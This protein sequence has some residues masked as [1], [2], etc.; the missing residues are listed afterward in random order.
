MK[1]TSVRAA[2]TLLAWIAAPSAAAQGGR[3]PTRVLVLF[4]QQAETQPMVEFTDW[5]RR[6]IRDEL[7]SPV[8][9]Y[10]EA[11][12]LDR[13]RGAGRVSPLAGYF[14]DKYRGF[15]I[16]VVVPVGGRALRF[17]L[18]HLTDILPNA[19]IVFA[20]NAA[21]QLEAVALP[22]NVTGRFAASSRFAP[23]LAMARR[24]QPGAEQVVVIAGDGTAD[25]NALSAAIGA[26]ETL[27]DTLPVT[28][29][30]G[31]TLQSLLGTLRQLSPR[32]IVL[33]A[34]FRQD[35][36]GQVFE[37]L[38]IIGSLARASA[39][40]MY[41][42]LRS[43]VGEGVVGGSVTSFADEGMRTAR[44]IV[45]VLRRRPG[46][47]MPR[48]EVIDN[49]FAVDWRQLRRWGLSEQLLPPAT[50]VLFREPTPWE[51]YRA[52]VLLALGLISAESFL[53]GRLL[54]ERRRRQ[55]AQSAVEEQ[56]EYERTMAHLTADTVRHA[57]D[58][59]PRGLE[60]ALARVAT[61]AGA[62]AAT[63]VQFAEQPLEPPTRLRW[64][65]AAGD[66]NGGRAVATAALLRTSRD[67]RIEIPL[68]ADGAV[69]GSLELYREKDGAG[70]PSFVVRRLDAAAEIIA[71]G[72][73]RARALQG[74]RRGEELNRAV[75]ASVST[76]I[77]LL[78]Q[79]GTIIRA[80]R[81][82]RDLTRGADVDRACNAFV[83]WNYLEEC[84]RAQRRGCDDAGVVCRGIE[85]VL[86]Q[87][88][89]PFRYEYHWSVPDERWYELFVDRLQLSEGGAIVTHLDVTNRRLAE[90]RAE[91]TR[92]QV[93]HMGRVALIGELA[94][95][96]SHELRQPL[97]AIR[98]NAEAGALLLER[99]PANVLEARD[100]FR[101]IVTEDA[102]AVE[103]IEGVRRLLRKDEQAA[104]PVDLNE[105]CRNTTRLL[106]HEV[107]ARNARLNLVLSPVPPLV[108]GDP[109]QLQQM[110]LNLT[111]N[112]LE[113]ASMSTNDHFVAITTASGGDEVEVSVRDS[114]P[115]IPATVQPHLFE[116]F[117]STKARGL[118]LGLVIVRS[119]VERHNGR[120]HAE[121]H[122]GRGTVFRVSLPRLT[123]S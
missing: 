67:M 105:I 88:S 29:V 28:V 95:A 84:R 64:V 40:P 109:I 35:G 111:L 36:H 51:R 18:D 120:I 27:G 91:E 87:R 104:T 118:G 1:L 10:Q 38:D 20:L 50:E 58:D 62:S 96:I 48:L 115:G 68:A 16:D 86:E 13:F 97:A 106:Q 116:A 83:G 57:P 89:C 90:R 85:A 101:A 94:A 92:R 69:I 30:Q 113:A 117:F 78:D 80:N 55:R 100:T 102:R 121:S 66:T 70:W 43:Y 65:R 63:L 31:S 54:L 52:A 77:V 11:L 47:A 2:T 14:E 73:A 6:T 81:A 112:G 56:T 98:A 59:A 39:A 25:S 71:S 9:F 23:T 72:M 19:P 21:P 34:N 42:Q 41:T 103:V 17:A 93:A 122:P 46:E 123:G 82:W 76:P 79:Q 12:D 119:I 37:P 108:T 24:L 74:I 32:S 61:Y 110:L 8:E 26:A 53:I 5:L 45:R 7:G 33:F 3:E 15:G 22:G 99:A 49:R 75:L 107:R 114:G 60:D 44:L 4:Q